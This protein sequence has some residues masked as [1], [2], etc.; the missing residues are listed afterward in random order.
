MDPQLFEQQ[1][2]ELLA[3]EKLPNSVSD[4]H[5]EVGTDHI[6]D[7]AVRVFLV[8]E[9]KF[10]AN[11][12]SESNQREELRKFRTELTFRILNLN[13]DYSPFIRLTEAA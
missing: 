10:A 9:P 7:P 3:T 8:L 2:R 12:E 6:G 5:F 13:A 4:I 11:F 1:L